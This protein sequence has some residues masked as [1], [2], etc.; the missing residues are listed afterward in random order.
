MQMDGIPLS[1]TKTLK[2]ISASQLDHL[3]SFFGFSQHKMA[4]IVSGYSLVL[5]DFIL[6]LP[7]GLN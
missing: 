2:R 1:Q 3:F 4:F 6:S 7:V 5:K